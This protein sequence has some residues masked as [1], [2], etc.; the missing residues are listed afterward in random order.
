VRPTDS[1]S[2]DQH[3]IA[4]PRFVLTRFVLVALAGIFVVGSLMIEKRLPIWVWTTYSTVWFVATALIIGFP[5][6][7]KRPNARQ[8]IAGLM[9]LNIALIIGLSAYGL[10]LH[11]Q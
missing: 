8:F 6:I 2:S 11:S 10:L 3:P 5:S 1:G 4:N 7:L 9:W